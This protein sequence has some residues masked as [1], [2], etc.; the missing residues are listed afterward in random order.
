LTA[1][2]L[3]VVIPVYNERALLPRLIERLDATPRPAGPGGE[4]MTRH[5]VLSDDGSTDGTA[6]W[7]AT[8]LAGRE[9]CTC[10]HAGRNAGK[11]AALARG[12]DAALRLGADLVLVQ[13]ADLEYDPADH[14][15]VL[16]PMVR[17]DADAVIGTRFLGGAHRV[18][19]Y[20]HSVA[21]RGLTTLSNMLS[22]LNLTDMECGTKAFTAR[23]LREITLRE[24]RFGVE[25]ELVARLARLRLPRLGDSAGGPRH[26]IRIYEVP[27]TYAG[28]TYAEGKKIGWRDGL[29]AV[30]CILRYNLFP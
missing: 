9:D 23:V 20:W 10:L 1:V 5:L 14:A 6:E 15:A 16:A 12:F 24:H 17:G 18:L 29:A 3:A 22:N 13:D 30:R 28:R 26:P 4:P 25:P 19:Y 7:I 2:L 27:V 11:G 21:N 8:A